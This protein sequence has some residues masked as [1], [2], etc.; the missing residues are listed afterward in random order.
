MNGKLKI[1]GV[2]M[3]PR[4]MDKA[5]N[6]G[7]ILQHLETAAR[8]GARLVVFPECALTGYCFE[9]L[10]EAKPHAEPIPGLSTQILAADCAKLDVWAVVGML[11][12][13]DASLS[14][15]YNACCLI[16]PNG[17]AATYRK[18]HLP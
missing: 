16:G 8:A 1:A 15:I 3:N 12:M 2:Q 7:A 14:M 17:V 5:G 11:E 13:A 6:L 18:V 9:S 4:L 10:Q